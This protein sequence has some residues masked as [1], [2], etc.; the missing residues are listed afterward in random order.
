MHVCQEMRFYGCRLVTDYF[1]SEDKEVGVKSPLNKMQQRPFRD[2]QTLVSG[3]NMRVFPSL[4]KGSLSFWQQ[5]KTSESLNMP[6]PVSLI[7]RAI[8]EIQIVW[9][10]LLKYI[11][12]YPCEFLVLFLM[13]KHN[14][15]S[16][17]IQ[18][19]CLR[20]R[21]VEVGGQERGGKKGRLEIRPCP[22]V[23]KTA[24]TVTHRTRLPA[25][26][27]KRHFYIYQGELICQS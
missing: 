3:F 27:T 10:V 5:G 1:A 23:A 7:S 9:I 14:L 18:L 15:V 26:T 16:F 19:F 24:A 17:E 25:D 11:F 22:L 13:R 4:L 2:T 21:E 8:T 6:F 20:C 12:Y